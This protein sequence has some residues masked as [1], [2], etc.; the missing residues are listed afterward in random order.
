MTPPL[1]VRCTRCG[2]GFRLDTPDAGAEFSSCPECHRR[3]WSLCANP[4]KSRRWGVDRYAAIVGVTPA[5]HAAW[6]DA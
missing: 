6:C 4:P 1:P 5:D 3:F 2:M